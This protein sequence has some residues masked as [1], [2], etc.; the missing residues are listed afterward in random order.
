MKKGE[1]ASPAVYFK[2]LEVT[3][4]ATGKPKQVPMLRMYWLFNLDQTTLSPLNTL[5]HEIIQAHTALQIRDNF[6][7]RPDVIQHPQLHYNPVDDKIGLPHKNDFTS[8]ALETPV[9]IL[10]SHS[11]S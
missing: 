8:E 2:M 11:L 10:S 1:K 3:D 4:T 5:E 7:D 9:P 6:H